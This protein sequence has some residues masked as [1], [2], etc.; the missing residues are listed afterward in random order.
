MTKEGLKVYESVESVP[1]R[2]SQGSKN[3][4]VFKSPIEITLVIGRVST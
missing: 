3:K 1:I 2:M 4:T